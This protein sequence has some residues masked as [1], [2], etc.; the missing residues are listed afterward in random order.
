MQ[1]G[2]SWRWL[3]SSSVV[4]STIASRIF[5]EKWFQTVTMRIDHFHP[6]WRGG[7]SPASTVRWLRRFRHHYNHDRPNQALDGRAD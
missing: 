4:G 1:A 2:I 6:F 3:A 7:G 5:I